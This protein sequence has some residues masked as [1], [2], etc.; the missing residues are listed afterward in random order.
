MLQ[1]GKSRLQVAATTCPSTSNWL[2]GGDEIWSKNLASKC[3]TFLTRWPNEET[4]CPGRPSQSW[5]SNYS[6]SLS[7]L[8]TCAYTEN[9]MHSRPK[10]Y[11]HQSH[12][13]NFWNSSAAVSSEEPPHLEQPGL[14]RAD[15]NASSQPRTLWADSGCSKWPVYASPARDL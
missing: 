14:Y 13:C 10:T 5:N 6:L 2:R 9:Y 8:L 1:V 3:P 11:L 12:A 4:S 7:L 15:N